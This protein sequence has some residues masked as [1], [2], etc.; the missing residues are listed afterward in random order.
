MTH[1][2]QSK[3]TMSPIQAA[4]NSHAVMSGAIASATNLAVTVINSRDQLLEKEAGLVFTESASL[5]DSVEKLATCCILHHNP[6][7]CRRK[8]YLQGRHTTASER[9]QGNVLLQEHQGNLCINANPIHVVWWRL[10]VPCIPASHISLTSLNLMML[11]CNKERWLMSS[12]STF[13]S[14]CRNTK[15]MVRETVTYF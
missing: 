4:L 10:Q 1:T 2:L 15:D 3:L 9:Q 12:L 14:I 7:V 5:D 6:Q 8:K 11:G 13:L